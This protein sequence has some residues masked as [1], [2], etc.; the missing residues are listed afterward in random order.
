MS[1]SLEELT[2][3]EK[4]GQM[5]LIGANNKY[6]DQ[7]LKEMIVDYKVGGVILY[8]KNYDSYQ[9]MLT[10]IN[11]LKELNRENNRIPLFIAIDQEGGRCNR[12]PKEFENLLSPTSITRKKD[13]ELVKRASKITAKMLVQS[14]INLNFAPVLD[15]KRFEDSHPIGNRCYGETVEEVCEYGITAMKKLKEEGMLAVVKHFPGHGATVTDS[16]MFLPIIKKK[17]SFLEK[18]DM[19]PFKQAIQDEADAMM[20]G[21][22]LVKGFSRIYPASLSKKCVIDYIRN[23]LGYQ[24]LILTDDLKMRAIQL[25][26]GSTHATK[27][28]FSAGNDIIIN[29]SNYSSIIRTIQAILK[30]SEKDRKIVD[31]IDDSV[32]RILEIKIKYK[33]TDERATGCDIEKINQEISDINKIVKTDIM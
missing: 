22:L 17:I 29:R 14:G 25:I 12:M 18:N 11:D 10:F 7:E 4:L 26:Y 1:N 16:H 21:H 32:N 9:D 23:K 27:L 2:L 15:I 8:R 31:R 3:Q 24:G 33:L 6:I 28:A 20:V 19:I 13:I 30:Q 5:F